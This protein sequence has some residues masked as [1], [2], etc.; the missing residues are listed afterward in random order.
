MTYGKRVNFT[1]EPLS[2]HKFATSA[3]CVFAICKDYCRSSIVCNAD[4]PVSKRRFIKPVTA[5][6]ETPLSKEQEEVPL[7][8]K[9]CT[10][11]I[12]VWETEQ[13]H[14]GILKVKAHN[15]EGVCI[16]LHANL[17]QH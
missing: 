3:K 5:P 10:Q 16:Y 11:K 8:K 17:T 9:E 7:A 1:I 2:L 14:R 12:A 6:T 13:T 15:P 4:I